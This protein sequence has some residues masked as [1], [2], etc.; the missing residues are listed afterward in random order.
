MAA[1]TDRRIFLLVAL[2]LAVVVTLML[3]VGLFRDA[4]DWRRGDEPIRPWMTVG[5]IARGAGLDPR[6]ID[7]RAGLPLPD[8]DPWTLRE[9]AK[10]RGVPVREI[11][12][13]VERTIAEMQATPASPAP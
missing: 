10:D 11:I 9:I 3:A 13:L 4:R 7:R 2:L 1:G 5:Y 8:P 12:D 6:E